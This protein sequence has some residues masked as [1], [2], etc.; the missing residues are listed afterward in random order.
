[1]GMRAELPKFFS[2]LGIRWPEY[3]ARQLILCFILACVLGAIGIAVT[4]L[5]AVEGTS[6]ALLK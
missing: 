6:D 4:M 3:S 1:M 2:R 5:R